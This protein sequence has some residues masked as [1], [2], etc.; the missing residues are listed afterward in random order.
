MNKNDTIND[1]ASFIY[2]HDH[3]FGFCGH[4]VQWEAMLQILRVAYNEGYRVGW[5]EATSEEK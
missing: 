3:E 5:H 1:L 4:D 2:C